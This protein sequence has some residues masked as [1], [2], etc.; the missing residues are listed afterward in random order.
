MWI[1]ISYDEINRVRPPEPT[2]IG[3]LYP[4]VMNKITREQCY[5]WVKD[6]YNYE[7]KK[8]ACVFCPYRDNLS[9]KQMKHHDPEAFAKA[10][11]FEKFI[12][13]NA[14]LL[15]LDADELFIHSSLVPLDQAD[16]EPKRPEFQEVN[17][18]DN[19]CFGICGV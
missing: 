11:A 16:F 17:P 15:N 8:S 14:H 12:N 19:E 7:L 1:G 10:V 6:N 3:N 13:A 9:W 2:Y 18:F 4:L 5:Q